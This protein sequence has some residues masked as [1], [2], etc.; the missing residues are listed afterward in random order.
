MRKS[1]VEVAMGL[2]TRVFPYL[3]LPKILH[4]DNGREFVN[5]IVMEC[6][7]LWSGEVVIINGR[8]RHS[9]SQ[10]L[11]EKGNHLVELQLQAMKAEQASK[12]VFPWSEWLPRVQCKSINIMYVI[13]ACLLT[14]LQIL[15]NL[16]T[17]LCRTIN[18]SP[19]KVVFG[20]PPRLSPF[21]KLT[22]DVRMECIMEEDIADLI[23]GVHACSVSCTLL[24]IFI[25]LLLADCD[26]AAESNNDHTSPHW[27]KVLNPYHLQLT[28][29]MVRYH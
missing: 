16:N 4:S 28:M 7:S 14:H 22:D 9:Q 19:Y 24:I 10:G 18:K 13:T 2:V 1:A 11:V 12:N 23:E 27:V 26:V 20:Q 5:A 6:L 21:P 15:D 8:P 3:G 25:I 17:Q 29:V